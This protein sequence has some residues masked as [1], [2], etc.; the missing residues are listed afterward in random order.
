MEIGESPRV[1]Q[2]T[3]IYGDLDWYQ[4]RPEMEREWSGTL[5]QRQTPLGPGMRGG[6]TFTL[7]T[8]K[9]RF[10][11][12]AANVEG[13]LAPLLAERVRLC[14]KLVDLSSQGDSEEL[15]IGSIEAGEPRSAV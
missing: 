6:L 9:G 14:G 5:E 2:M 7:V 4:I 10:P 15:W 3:Q 11:V 1:A 8:D 13:L 12:Y